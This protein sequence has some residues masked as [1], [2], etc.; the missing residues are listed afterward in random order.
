VRNR[1][2]QEFEMLRAINGNGKKRG[3]ILKG[4]AGGQWRRG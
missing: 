4:S 2:K 1:K 3:G